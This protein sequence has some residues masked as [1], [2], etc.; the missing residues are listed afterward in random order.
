MKLK[1]TRQDPLQNLPSKQDT[2]LRIDCHEFRI[3]S[4]NLHA[5]PVMCM[6]K[7]T[8]CATFVLVFESGRKSPSKIQNKFSSWLFHVQQ[9]PIWDYTLQSKL[10]SSN[11][12]STRQ[13]RS[14]SMTWHLDTHEDMDNLKTMLSCLLMCQTWVCPYFC[15]SSNLKCKLVPLL[16]A[17]LKVSESCKVLPQP[18][19]LQ[20]C[21]QYVT[22]P[23][24]F[25]HSTATGSEPAHTAQ[26]KGK[27]VIGIW[28]VW[29]GTKVLQV[30]RSGYRT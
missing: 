9:L 23:P 4:W 21:H 17:H 6:L 22:M 24:H 1:R 14:F 2:R 26:M 7:Q 12:I 3:L 15:I 19:I 18:E 8:N 25:S 13:W 10:V 29:I 27:V 20:A 30:A 16:Q 28:G 5:F 11:Q